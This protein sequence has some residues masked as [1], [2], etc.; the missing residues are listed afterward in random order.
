MHWP[1]E[2]KS[3][4]RGSFRPPPPLVGV[5]QYPGAARC[6]FQREHQMPQG[7]ATRQ[8]RA[9]LPGILGRP[10][11]QAAPASGDSTL[12][13]PRQ[14]LLHPGRRSGGRVRAGPAEHLHCLGSLQVPVAG[15]DWLQGLRPSHPRCALASTLAA[16]GASVL[17]RFL[18]PGAG[19]GRPAAGAA[20]LQMGAAAGI[21]GG[22]SGERRLRARAGAR[23][24][25]AAEVCARVWSARA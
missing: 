12:T 10:R 18:Q 25:S 9:R 20:A 11:F 19:A 22:G 14:P 13:K 16:S 2:L 3:N 8:S 17:A 15:W 7:A 5:G 23:G 21:R 4:A 1:A 6:P 24:A